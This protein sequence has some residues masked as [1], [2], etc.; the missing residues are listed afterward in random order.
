MHMLRTQYDPEI[1]KA[2]DEV[3]LNAIRKM[4]ADRMADPR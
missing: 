2:M 3:A 1:N 4:F